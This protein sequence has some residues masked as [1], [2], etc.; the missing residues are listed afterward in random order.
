MSILSRSI[1][2]FLISDILNTLNYN[3]NKVKNSL[4]VMCVTLMYVNNC[5]QVNKHET[6]TNEVFFINILFLYLLF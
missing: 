6:Q 4:R 2:H 3:I 1:P 5:D